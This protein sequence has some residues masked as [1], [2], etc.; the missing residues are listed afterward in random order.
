VKWAA[1]ILFGVTALATGCLETW[2]GFQTQP[3][4][5]TWSS[6]YWWRLLPMMLVMSS[7]LFA[8][9]LSF[10]PVKRAYSIGLA[11]GIP[12]VLCSLIHSLH[13]ACFACATILACITFLFSAWKK[14]AR[15]APLVASFG[16]AAW[17]VPASALELRLHF[18]PA[19]LQPA[20]TVFLLCPALLVVASLLVATMLSKCS[21]ST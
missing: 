14:G 4:S 18:R 21:A 13:L 8:C 9:S 5:G 6:P 20:P 12:L 1:A 3:I 16:L 15:F 7:V 17:W 10:I 2:L 11:G 19:P